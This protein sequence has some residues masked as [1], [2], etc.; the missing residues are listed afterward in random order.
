MALVKPVIEIARLPLLALCLITAATLAQP[1]SAQNNYCGPHVW[2]VRISALDCPLRPY[3]I[4][5]RPAWGGH[6]YRY[7]VTIADPCFATGGG[8]G[9]LTDEVGQ[10]DSFTYPAELGEEFAPV[11]FEK[12]GQIPNDSLLD[13]VPA[14]R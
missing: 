9:D 5:R 14:A 3:F 8:C 6:D 4:P 1:A 2:P 11:G 12:L 7:R 10:A 13:S